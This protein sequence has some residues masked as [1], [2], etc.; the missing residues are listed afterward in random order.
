MIDRNRNV[1][2]LNIEAQPVE[3]AH[4][5]VGDPYQSEPCDDISTPS[6]EQHP[7]AKDPKGQRRDIMREAV[8]A[9]EEVEE[10]AAGE[11]VGAFALALAE[12]AR[13][14]KHLFVRNG[15]GNARDRKREQQQRGSLVG[16]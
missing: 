10:L 12:L 3:E 8:L 2:V 14:A 6:R 1:L 15:P 11:G 4:V 5:Y 16:E 7:E 13:F 9:C